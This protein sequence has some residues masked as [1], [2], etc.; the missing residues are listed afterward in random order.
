MVSNAAGGTNYSFEVGDIMM[1]TDHIN[2]FGTNPL[3]GKNHDTLGPRF[4]DM[5]KAYNPALCETA[6][7]HAQKNNIRMH[8]GVYAGLT[9]PSFETPAEYRFLNTIGAD[10]VGMSTVPEVIV[11]NHMSMKVFGLSVIT[12]NGLDLPEHGN[13]HNEVVDVAQVAAPNVE[14]VLG[15]VI[16]SLPPSVRDRNEQTICY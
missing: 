13:Q 7:N 8:E 14:S 10:A 16:E 4:P 11:A 3:I 5:S 6:H 2:L 1:I 9:G 12:N 15:A